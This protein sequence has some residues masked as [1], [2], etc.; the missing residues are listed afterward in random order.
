MDQN[1]RPELDAE[2]ATALR[3]VT[4][5]RSA[6]TDFDRVTQI[7]Q[8]QTLLDAAHGALARLSVAFEESQLASQRSEG[9]LA[10]ERGRGISDQIALARRIT[11]TQASHD[12]GLARALRDDLPITGQL[13]SAGRIH[14]KV[15][16]AVH[17]ETSHLGRLHRRQ[18]DAELGPMLAEATPRRAAAAARRIALTI[19]PDSAAERTRR[20][21][22]ERRVWMK[23]APDGMCRLGA[24]LPAAQA[25][26][27]YNALRRDA[28]RMVADGSSGGR[29][30]QQ[31]MADLLVERLTGQSSAA[32]IPVEVQVVMTADQLFGSAPPQDESARHGVDPDPDGP[33]WL[34]GYGPIPAA[35][36]RAI[37]A[38][39]ADLLLPDPADLDRAHAWVRRIFVDP[40]TGQLTDV[41]SRRRRF[42]GVVRRFIQI[43]DRHCR[44]PQCDAPIR[45][46]DHVQRHSDDGPTSVAN[47]AGVCRRFNLVKEMPGWSTE[48]VS[49]ADPPDGRPHRIKITTPTGK[50]YWSESPP[51]HGSRPVPPK[52]SGLEIFLAGRLRLAG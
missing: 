35:I 52:F 7:E 14:A 5:T 40:V 17:N 33:A 25:V 16:E 4:G 21:F 34:G 23:P 49:G 47:G 28:A 29:T 31:T 20:A 13:L 43:R 2:L 9:V 15:A 48:V 26:A 51:V 3:L 46:H 18:V 8:L 50:T 24:E 32:A 12:L 39:T 41:D 11:P 37:A 38:G 1:Q 42:D 44:T 22:R 36:A 10:R 6:A 19:D 30:L 27:A 45:D